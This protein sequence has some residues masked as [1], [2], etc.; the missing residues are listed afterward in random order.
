MD[1]DAPFSHVFVG[2]QALR[3][4]EEA[5]HE[6]LEAEGAIETLKGELQHTM[7][8]LRRAEAQLQ[9]N[10]ELVTQQVRGRLMGPRGK[11]RPGTLHWPK[12]SIQDLPFLSSALDCRSKGTTGRGTGSWHGCGTRCAPSRPHGCS[13]SRSSRTASTY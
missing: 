7:A 4:A 6:R 11:G 10:V 3:S 5:H 9:R 13:T 2:V 8:Q 1:A 12:R